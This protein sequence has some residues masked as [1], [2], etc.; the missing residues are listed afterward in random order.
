MPTAN[1]EKFIKKL[2]AAI[3]H[4]LLAELKEKEERLG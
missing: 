2:S 3:S 1:N 4:N